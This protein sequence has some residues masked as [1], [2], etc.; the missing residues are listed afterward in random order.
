MQQLN[1]MCSDVQRVN[2]V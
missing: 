1:D 2:S